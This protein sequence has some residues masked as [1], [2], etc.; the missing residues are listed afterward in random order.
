MTASKDESLVIAKWP[1]ARVCEAKV[2]PGSPMQYAVYIG[3][4]HNGR[5]RRSRWLPT[6][7]EAWADAAER[8]R[9]VKAA[10][11]WSL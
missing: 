10:K 9:T 5:R 4:M 3:P 6:P 7:D 8:V 2:W 11:A 1:T